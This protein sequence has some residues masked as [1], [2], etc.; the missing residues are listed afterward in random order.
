MPV[1]I[2][3]IAIFSVAAG[4]NYLELDSTNQADS[5]EKKLIQVNYIEMPLP[6][7]PLAST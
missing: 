1:W 6:L 4:S 2:V 7:K 5:I 3:P